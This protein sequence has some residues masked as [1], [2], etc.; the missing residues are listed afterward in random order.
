MAASNVTDAV[1]LLAKANANLE[2]DLLTMESARRQLDEYAR[3]EKL[4]SYGRTVLAA[5]I[6]EAATVARTTGTSM[7]RPR[8][9]SRPVHLYETHQRSATRWRA[10]RCHWTRQAR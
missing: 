4:A 2:P 6:D 5:R 9:R 1:E 10:G 8:R 3:A 7:G